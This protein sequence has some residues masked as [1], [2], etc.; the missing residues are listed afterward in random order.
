MLASWDAGV[1]GYYA[2]RPVMNLDGVANS[3]AYYEA[4]RDGEVGAF[5]TERGLTGIVNHGT[6]VDGEDPDV[7]AFVRS[8]FGETVADGARVVRQWPFVFSGVTTGAGGTGSG[9]RPL[10]VFLYELP[11]PPPDAP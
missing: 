7:R 4:S 5:L 8:T 1:V 10:A 11:T 9:T 2:N 6:P 3:Y